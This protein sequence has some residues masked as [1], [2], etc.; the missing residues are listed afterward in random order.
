MTTVA[1]NLLGR[2]VRGR[3][4]WKNPEYVWPKGYVEYSKSELER[5]TESQRTYWLH[6]DLE[7]QVIAV[8]SEGIDD[9]EKLKFWILVDGRPVKLTYATVMPAGWLPNVERI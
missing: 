5:L 8:T 4:H 1:T 6:E 9:D 2:W 7:G 3:R